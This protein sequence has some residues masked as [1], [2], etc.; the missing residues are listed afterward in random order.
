MEF[1]RVC[2]FL[3]VICLPVDRP[4]HPP[5]QLLPVDVARIDRERILRAG[6]KY[7]R[8]PPRTITAYS[9]P[10]SAGG[11]HEYFSEGDYWWPDPNNPD[12]PYIQR[13]G[14][15][16]PDNFVA[17]RQALI[18]LSLI[19]PALAS[20]YQIT[21]ERGYAAQAAKHLRAWF[22]DEKTKMVPHLKYA[23]AI[24]GRFTGR[25]TGIIDTLHLVEV[26]RAMPALESAD[27]LSAAELE[28]H[29]DL[30]PRLPGLDDHTPIWYPGARCQ[31]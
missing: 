6:Q 24:K 29:Q 27:A 10:R 8:E 21:R 3:L 11:S 9:S 23:Q 5:A 18:R 20:A 1:A 4:L 25:G 30:V 26:A 13:D 14:M 31:E 12:G 7:L 28:R 22:L 16:N 19:V 17:H 15:S 2:T